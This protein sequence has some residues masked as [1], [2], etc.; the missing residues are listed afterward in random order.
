V[1]IVYLRKL[2]Q[3]S[4][5]GSPTLT[6]TSGR[7]AEAYAAAYKR[8]QGIS[9]MA[10]ITTLP[11]FTSRVYMGKSCSLVGINNHILGTRTSTDL[12]P[13]T[14]KYDIRGITHVIEPDNLYSKFDLVR[15]NY[16]ATKS[17]RENTSVKVKDLVLSNLRE[18]LYKLERIPEYKTADSFSVGSMFGKVNELYYS[19]PDPTKSKRI[20]ELKEQISKIEGPN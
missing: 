9:V 7:Y 8:L 11:L 13:Y 14:G 3:N 2:D 15:S 12:A 18:E 1:L 5:P 20:K 19:T 4:P 16:N 10:D 6:T 17:L